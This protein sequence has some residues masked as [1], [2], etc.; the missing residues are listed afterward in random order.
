MNGQHT[1]GQLAKRADVNVETVRFYERKGLIEQP[2]APGGG[3][4]KYGDDVVRRI[5]FI[6]RA[7]NLGFTLREIAELL[8]LS[9]TGTCDEVR[10]KAEHKLDEVSQKI[11][12]LQR[13]KRALKD[14]IQTCNARADIETCPILA[15]LDP[16]PRA[17]S[18]R[19]SASPKDPQ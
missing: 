3:F 1:I 9:F 11:R 14:V 17:R 4:R 10:L 15:A 12:D 6:K 16:K 13:M 5:R 8:D 2:Q 7:Q 18:S 19:R